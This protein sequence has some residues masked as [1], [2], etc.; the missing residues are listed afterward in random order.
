MLVQFFAL[1]VI[2]TPL[3][4][5]LILNHNCQRLQ[6][7]ITISMYKVSMLLIRSPL[8]PYLMLLESYNLPHLPFL[9]C[10]IVLISGR[11]LDGSATS[12]LKSLLRFINGSLGLTIR[13]LHLFFFLPCPNHGDDDD[14]DGVHLDTL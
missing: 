12:G 2:D 3:A 11:S 10:C 13:H 14:S 5:A 6:F 4:Q 7:Y 8:R 1:C 9:W